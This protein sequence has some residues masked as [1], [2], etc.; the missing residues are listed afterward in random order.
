ML[1]TLSVAGLGQE[2]SELLSVKGYLLCESATV[3]GVLSS[4][5]SLVF[6][7]CLPTLG[8]QWTKIA[9]RRNSAKRVLVDFVAVHEPENLLPGAILSS[10]CSQED[11]IA[12]GVF[13][14]H[15]RAFIWG[16]ETTN[17]R[18]AMHAGQFMECRGKCLV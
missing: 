5:H 8:R 6:I 9:I 18:Q 10:F 16:E 15:E 11:L 4:R 1:Y 14:E 17:T 3:K 7:S 2:R 13:R 12:Q